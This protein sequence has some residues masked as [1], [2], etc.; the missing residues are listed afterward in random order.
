[1]KVSHSPKAQRAFLL[2]GGKMNK[3]RLMKLILAALFLAAAYLLPFLTGSNFKLGQMFCPMHI[4]VMLC[5][6][7]CGPVWGL[8]V[9]AVA[10]ILRGLTVGAPAFPVTALPMAFELA[11]YGLSTGL[12][13]KL[14]PKKFVF[15]YPNLLISMVLGRVVNGLVQYV[16]FSLGVTEKAFA[17]GVYVN[18]VTVTAIPAIIIQLAVIPPLVMLSDRLLKKYKLD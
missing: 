17:L 3:K 8:V 12:L 5:G 15:L 18:T 13:R 7:I 11:V 4:P 2:S 1:M 14:F 16:M 6:M 9:G 10:P